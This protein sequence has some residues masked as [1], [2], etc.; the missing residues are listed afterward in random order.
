MQG[1][2][3]IFTS[4]PESLRKRPSFTPTKGNFFCQMT[5]K[6][7]LQASTLISGAGTSPAVLAA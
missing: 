7:Q 5:W 6:A 2:A 1:K 4:A 3:R